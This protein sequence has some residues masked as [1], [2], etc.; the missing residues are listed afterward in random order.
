MVKVFIAYVRPILE[1]A[2]RLWS[3]SNVNVINRIER[4]Q[5]LF[6]K[7]IWSV[8]H[9]PY[10]E[11]L[12]LQRLESGRL[13]LDVLFLAKLKFNYFHLTL[14]D[15]DIRVS[16]LHNNGFISLPS[17]SRVTYY[18]YTVRMIRL[19]N[20]LRNNF[21]ASRTIYVLRRLLSNVS[22]IPYL[23]GCA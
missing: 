23:R 22:F 10:N 12:G 20:S 21:T 18:F 3:P 16:N 1:Y 15:F 7:R 2:S 11:R 4:V 19:W 6:T 5:R 8:A 9:L 14:N 17:Y 13:Y